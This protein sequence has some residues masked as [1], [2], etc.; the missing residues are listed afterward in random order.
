MLCAVGDHLLRCVLRG[1]VQPEHI[2]SEQVVV[3]FVREVQEVVV[4][5]DP[6]AGNADVEFIAEVGLELGEAAF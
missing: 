4:A 1:K 2:N 5:V 3:F 6:G